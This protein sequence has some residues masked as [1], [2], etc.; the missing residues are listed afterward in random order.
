[1][2]RVSVVL[3]STAVALIAF[4][5]QGC[6]SE[7]VVS[8]VTADATPSRAASS[9]TTVDIQVSP[10]TIIIKEEGEWV[11][12]HAAIPYSDV[13]TDTVALEGIP[14]ALTFADACGDLVAK[15]ALEDV[16]TIIAPPEATLTLTGVTGA[17]DLFEGS[18]TVRVSEKGNGR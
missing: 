4:A 17:G 3:V 8:P 11:T 1:M 10:A 5:G 2:V 18:D 14:A 6:S 9:T 7:G 12:V 15:F 13:A 16:L